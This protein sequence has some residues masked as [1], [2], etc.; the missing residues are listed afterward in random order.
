VDIGTRQDE[1]GE[2]GRRQECGTAD[3]PAD[4]L[5]HYRVVTWWGADGCSIPRYAESILVCPLN[6]VLTVGA[7]CCITQ[8]VLEGCHDWSGGDKRVVRFVHWDVP[9]LL[10]VQQL[11]QLTGKSLPCSAGM[12]VQEC[13]QRSVQASQDTAMPAVSLCSCLGINILEK[14]GNDPFLFSGS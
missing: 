3:C 1:S 8:T 10:T 5:V 6:P 2:A 11:G 12:Q 13:G 7:K 9:W 4:S 14:G